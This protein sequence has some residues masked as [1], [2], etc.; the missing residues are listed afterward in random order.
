MPYIF[1]DVIRKWASKGEQYSYC[2]VTVLRRLVFLL[3]LVPITV[4]GFC[5]LTDSCFLLFSIKQLTRPL[6]L[7]LPTGQPFVYSD[8]FVLDKLKIIPNLGRF[9]FFCD[10]RFRL[11]RFRKKYSLIQQSCTYYLSSGKLGK[12]VKAH[13]YIFFVPIMIVKVQRSLVLFLG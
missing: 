3:A 6:A 13:L 2:Y 11:N 5:D 12:S 7:W 8:N 9:C 1:F 10:F 4:S